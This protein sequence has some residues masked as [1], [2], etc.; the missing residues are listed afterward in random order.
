MSTKIDNVQ[1]GELSVQ[2]FDSVDHVTDYILT[3]R[4]DSCSMAVAIN[5]EKIVTASEDPAVLYS[6]KSADILY[7]D[8]IGAS[9]LA[10]YRLG[11]KVSRVPG[12]ELWE[13][14][15]EKSAVTKTPVYILGSA[16]EVV[17]AT[18]TK[19]TD[20]GV[21]IVGCRDGYFDDEDSLIEEI[22]LSEA[23]ILCVA[24]G[25]PKQELFMLK[26][27][28]AG[29]SCFMMG[30]G[31]TYDVFVGKVNRAPALFRNLNLEW[32]YRLVVQPSRILRQRKLPK[33]LYMLVRK[34]I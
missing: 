10:S 3:E 19:L 17:Q 28:E 1:I 7:L 31:G 15:M 25:S 6:L 32:A 9:K 29:L 21:N 11:R 23:K 4:L 8:G 18:V 16:S 2:C 30:V 13:L 34:K 33:F 24:M 12:C 20:L 14:L 26:C 5:P 22:R 27:R